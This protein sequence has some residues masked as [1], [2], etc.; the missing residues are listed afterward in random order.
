MKQVVETLRGAKRRLL[1]CAHVQCSKSWTV[2]QLSKH[3]SRK[4]NGNVEKCQMMGIRE[5][6]DISIAY[7]SA[8][9]A[10]LQSTID[11]LSI[12]LGLSSSETKKFANNDAVNRLYRLDIRKKL[13]FMKFIGLTQT[14]LRQVIQR[15][16][17]VLSLSVPMMK[18]A[19]EVYHCE[20]NVTKNDLRKM[21]LRSPRILSNS[22]KLKV[23][24]TFLLN[25]V[26][27]STAQV[28][29]TLLKYPGLLSVSVDRKLRPRV[30]NL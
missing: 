6:T 2:F 4:K 21:L 29:K 17:A 3:Q 27:C 7:F 12:D 30:R 14:E 24:I 5:N 25:E 22:K 11:T 19:L 26:G 23:V 1:L 10:Y 18:S 20:L 28:Q 8:F 15:R 16:P 13:H 9:F